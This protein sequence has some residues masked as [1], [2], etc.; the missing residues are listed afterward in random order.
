MLVFE[1]KMIRSYKYKEIELQYNELLK[2]III[3]DS[4]YMHDIIFAVILSILSRYRAI[5]ITLT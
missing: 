2:T 1:V 4:R 5:T 3:Y